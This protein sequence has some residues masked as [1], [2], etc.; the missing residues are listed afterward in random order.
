MAGC[1]TTLQHCDQ[2]R[3][4]SILPGF[5]KVRIIKHG[6]MHRNT[7]FDSPGLLDSF[8]KVKNQ[9]TYIVGQLSGIDGYSPAISS[10]LVSSLRIIFG[11]TLPPLPTQTM[12]GAL[13]NYVSNQNTVDFQPM[14]ASFS[15][16]KLSDEADYHTASMRALNNYIAHFQN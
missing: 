11:E 16:I 14:C 1:T 7:F 2:L 5:S 6:R 4:I 9:D 8:Y 12:I 13:A 3:A 10:G 15:L